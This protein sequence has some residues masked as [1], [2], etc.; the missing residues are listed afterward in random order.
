M[1]AEFVKASPTFLTGGGRNT[2]KRS[3]RILRIDNPG[4]GTE[5]QGRRAIHRKTPSLVRSGIYVGPVHH[6]AAISTNPYE[7]S[8]K[9]GA[10]LPIEA[11]S[12][13]LCLC[14]SRDRR[15]VIADRRPCCRIRNTREYATSVKQSAS[16]ALVFQGS[17]LRL[18][19]FVDYLSEIACTEWGP[20]VTVV[21]YDVPPNDFNDTVDGWI[22]CPAT[23]WYSV[24]CE[25]AV[26]PLLVILTGMF[27]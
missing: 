9:L 12:V 25:R 20:M 2:R 4:R 7:S 5:C 10:R 13:R 3:Q 22:D 15:S 11:R 18:E 24:P 16:W 14:R 17:G 1:G 26:K 6:S 19:P 21:E 27:V 23:I 8:V